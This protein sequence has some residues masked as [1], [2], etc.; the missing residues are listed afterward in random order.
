MRRKINRTKLFS[1]AFAALILSSGFMMLLFADLAKTVNAQIPIRV[2]CVGDS[3]TEGSGYPASLQTMLGSNYTVGNFGAI[4]SSVSRNSN[5][6][7]LS[8]AQFW[9]AIKFQPDIVIIMLG[10]NDASESNYEVIDNFQIT[11]EELIAKFQALPG[12]Q[13]VVLVEPPPILNNTLSLSDENLVQ[14]VIPRI[15]RVADD[16]NLPTVD[17]YAALTNHTEVFGDGVHPNSEGG[18]IIAEQINQIINTAATD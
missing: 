5:K 15:A 6:P 16:L 3:I 11:Y 1:I 9:D 10:T 13:Q 12:D 7:Y 18:Q 2:A 8:Q 14:G 17:V 4:G